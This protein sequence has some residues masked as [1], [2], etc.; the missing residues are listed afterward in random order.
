ML[1]FGPASYPLDL[2]SYAWLAF[3]PLSAGPRTALRYA[4]AD[5]HLR[6]LHP[7]APH[8]YLFVLGVDPA[9]QGRGLGSR[10]LEEL[11]ASADRDGVPCYLETD[12]E[13][14]VR[15]YQRHGFRVEHDETEPR[16]GLRFWTMSR[17]T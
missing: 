16:L 14:S 10:M 6:R 9:E 1:A 11:C 4:L 2:R 17:P 12:K 5:R 13:S 3:G 8:W 15:L 7:H